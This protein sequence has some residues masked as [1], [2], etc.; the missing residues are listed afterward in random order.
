MINFSCQRPRSSMDRTGACGASN[1]GST[2]LEGTPLEILLTK[3]LPDT[4]FILNK[5]WNF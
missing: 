5:I 2:P 4:N 3:L 1:R